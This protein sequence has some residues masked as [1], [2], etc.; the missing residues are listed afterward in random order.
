MS[1]M[2]EISIDIENLLIDGVSRT[3]IAQRLNVPIDWV[4]GVE[5]AMLNH[6]QDDLDY[7]TIDCDYVSF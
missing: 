4:Y 6:P 2:S 3:D 1:R 7:D 5:S